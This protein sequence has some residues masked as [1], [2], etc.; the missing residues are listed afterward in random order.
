[1]WKGNAVRRGRKEIEKGE[2]ELKKLGEESEKSRR[3]RMQVTE[4]RDLLDGGFDGPKRD[5][6]HWTLFRVERK[7]AGE[8][9]TRL[10]L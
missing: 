5:Q 3:Q 10:G 1:V 7:R 4:K 8:T 2:G 6:S 9:E